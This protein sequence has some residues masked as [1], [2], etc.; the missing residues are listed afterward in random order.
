MI[1]CVRSFVCVI[2]QGSCRGCIARSP[3]KL[4]TGAGSSP[5]CTASAVKS[6]VRPSSRGGVPVFKRPAGS[7][8]SRRRAPSVFAGGSPARPAS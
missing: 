8:S 2:Q 5:G 4:I 7:A 6:I 3:T 1:S